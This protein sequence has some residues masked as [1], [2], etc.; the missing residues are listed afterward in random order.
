MAVNKKLTLG[1][2]I[3]AYHVNTWSKF[4]WTRISPTPD[5]A[6]GKREYWEAW[7][8]GRHVADFFEGKS[9]RWYALAFGRGTLR[10][11]SDKEAVLHTLAAIIDG[12]RA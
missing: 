4:K 12:P 1:P 2:Q 11:Y 6:D 3:V 9:G 8:R 7:Y 10:N 5:Y